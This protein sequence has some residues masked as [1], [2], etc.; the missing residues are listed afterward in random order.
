MSNVMKHYD[1][2][3]PTYHEQYDPDLLWANA[4][5]PANL[6]RLQLVARLLKA[7]G[8]RSVYELGTGEATPMIKLHQALGINV[9]GS[10]LS[11]EMVRLGQENLERHGLDAGLLSLVDAQ[12]EAAVR[13]E[14]SLRGE[15][16]AVIALGVIP[17][18]TDDAAFV[19]SMSL[20]CRPG[21]TL[22]LQFRNSMFSMFTFNRLTKEFILD[23]LMAPVPQ[24]FKDAVAADLD[25]R[26]AVDMPRVR[27]RDDGYGYDEVLSRFHNPFELADVVRAE[28]YTDVRFHW[29]NYHPTY[30]MLRGQF[31]DRA[32]REAQMALEQEGTWRG[33]FLCSS[34]VIEATRA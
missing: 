16:D 13:A 3:A 6:F 11:P 8:A 18:V 22:L 2:S 19:R 32:Y 34:G 25:T 31:E 33:M 24:E 26:L 12:D 23:E 27:R 21:G 17:H 7:A 28:G 9:A 15:S 4:E 20:F 14:R 30:P 29:Y 10:D 1:G 5:Y